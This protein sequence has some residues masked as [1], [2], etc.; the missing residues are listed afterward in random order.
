MDDAAVNA[1]VFQALAIEAYTNLAGMFIIGEKKFYKKH[2]GKSNNEKL[3]LLEESLEKAFSSELKG[4]IK[5]LFTKRN[6]L[7]HQ[8]PKSFKIE[9]K[10]FDYS[11]LT[12]NYTDIS[13]I[14]DDFCYAWSNIDEE[15]TLYQAMQN[16]LTA[17]RGTGRELIDEL[18]KE[19]YE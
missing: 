3:E 15:M 7:V 19:L 10:D 6:K 14:F 9:M 16:E 12:S 1:V 17:M 2:E 4:K 18:N 8:K 5:N 11:D 13:K